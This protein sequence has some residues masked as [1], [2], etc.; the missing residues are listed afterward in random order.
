M[1]LTS[2]HILKAA[3]FA[4]LGALVV[5]GP[6]LAS[7]DR[8]DQ[9]AQRLMPAGSC[10]CSGKSDCTCKKG[11]CKCAKCGS[12]DKVR[13]FETLK[14]ASAPLKLPDTARYEATGGIF[15]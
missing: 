10:G 13:V 3:R 12:H 2:Q 9:L 8:A 14:G 7:T 15:I 6:A 5:G 1:S 4:A 11:Q